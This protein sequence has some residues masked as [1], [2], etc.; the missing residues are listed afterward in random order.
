[1]SSGVSSGS[2]STD[3]SLKQVSKNLLS[4]V[5]MFIFGMGISF[6]MVPYYIKS[7]GV[8]AYGL[9]PLATSV[10]GYASILTI[11]ISG[12]TARFFTL[13]YQ[14]GDVAQA[15]RV[16][17][18]AFW[19]LAA[20]GAL[21]LPV[22][23]LLSWFAAS[24]FAGETVSPWSARLL[25]FGASAVFLLST[26]TSSF[27]VSYQATNRLDIRN[28]LHLVQLVLQPALVVLLFTLFEP[29][30][31]FVAASLLTGSAVWMVLNMVYWRRLIPDVW[32]AGRMFSRAR[33]KEQM[34]MGG[35]LVVNHVGYIL[36]LQIDLVVVNSLIGK[37]EAGEYA[38]VLQWST[39][40]RS[41][42]G[43]LA[44][45]LGPVI[46]IRYAQ[47]KFSEVATLSAL[48]VRLLGLGLAIPIGLACGF[49]EPLLLLWL[50]EE[51]TFLAPLLSLLLAPLV[52]NLSVLPLFNI[53]VCYN[54][55]KVPGL[56]T[57][58]MGAFNLGLAILLGSIDSLGVYGVAIAGAVALS[59]KNA[60]FTPIYAAH[61]QGLR[62]SRFL[63]SMLPGV[64]LF[65]AVAGSA[66][67]LQAALQ[68]STW[69]QLLGLF[70]ALGAG[71]GLVGLFLFVSGK[72]RRQ[73][74][75]MVRKQR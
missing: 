39:L 34:T 64:L 42:A 12:G 20:L 18:T 23:A 69:F 65:A 27:A 47:K 63:G 50:G 44:G 17:N 9:I 36:F 10:V 35:W 57:V 32:P 74:L 7:L 40:I 25:F 75:S 24:W 68:I 49:S 38:S 14:Q 62:W 70:A 3:T 21:L 29:R 22:L 48:S 30:L 71:S 13:A 46:L 58:G 73:L 37:V 67:A 51:F 66:F 26:L 31:E 1:M 19:A 5:F 59:A 33:L 55:V 41:F 6:F 2:S 11:A 4:N 45:V 28:N 61:V 60:L 54:K 8:E 52:I 56:I 15:Q 53:N 43:V 72:E 16:I